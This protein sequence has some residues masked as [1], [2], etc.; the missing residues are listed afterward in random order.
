MPYAELHSI[1]HFTFL[2][3]ASWPGELVATA[4]ELNY[5]AIAICDECSLAGIVK[6][7]IA[8][9]ANNIKL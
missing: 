7:H 6:A 1:S 5:H 2:R 3:G 9:K 8:A 4:A